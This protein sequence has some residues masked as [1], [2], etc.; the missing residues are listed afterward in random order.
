MSPKGVVGCRGG[1]QRVSWLLGFKVS[2]ICQIPI[3]CFEEDI[4]PNS[5]M[6]ET[7][8]DESAGLMA[9]V[10]SIIVKQLDFQNFEIYENNVFLMFQ[11]FVDFV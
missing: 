2:K 6:F 1:N 7:L 9:P 4:G 11:M 8:L 5:R 3:S 10:F